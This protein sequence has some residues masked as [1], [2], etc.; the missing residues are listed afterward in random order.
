MKDKLTQWHPAFYSAIQLELI[1]DRDGLEFDSE[2]GINTKPIQIDVLIIR[3]SS[4]TPISNEIGRIFKGHNII[5]YKSPDDTLNI[6]TFYKTIGYACLYKS[7]NVAYVNAIKA[8]DITISIIRESKPRKLFSQLISLG[9]NVVSTSP[10][11]YHIEYPLPLSFD[12]Q[13]I[14][15]GEMDHLQH[16]WLT[17]LTKHLLPPDATHLI[18]KVNRLSGSLDKQLADSVLEV[19]VTENRKTFSNVKE[20]EINMCKALRELMKPEF[21]EYK[22]QITEEVT[23]EVTR[24]VTKEVTREVTREVTKEVTARV[25]DQVTKD[26]TIKVTDQVTKEITAVY[27]AELAKKDALIASLMKQ[28]AK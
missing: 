15:Y 11:I 22:A 5:E 17:S 24:E 14:A 27:E 7:T 18:H 23:R 4:S 12:I 20:A 2:Y 1:D 21:D 25:T 8:D 28:L 13:I 26:V 9:F 19:A 16:S 6:D 3:K 10:G